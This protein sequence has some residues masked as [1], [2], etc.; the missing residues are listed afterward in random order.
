MIGTRLLGALA[1][2]AGPVMAQDMVTARVAAS[3]DWS[4]FAE[5]NPPYCI[6]AS[7]PLQQSNTRDGQ[8]VEVSRG[9]AQLSVSFRPAE[10]VD[11]QVTFTGGYPFAGSSIVTLDV[12]GTAFQLFTEGDWA[13]AATPEE[14]A[15]IVAALKNGTEAVLTGQ[16]GR[17]TVTRDTF[18]LRGFTAA[19]DEARARCAG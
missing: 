15:R 8:P 2:L 3:A 11:G 16:S 6:T 5:G 17:G 10:G 14:D 9:E 18:S 1:L 12:G 13:W 19:V 7:G 4:A